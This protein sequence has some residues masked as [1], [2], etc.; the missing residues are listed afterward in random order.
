MVTLVRAWVAHAHVCV[1]R[2]CVALAALAS[3]CK[4]E[5]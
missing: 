3:V 1:T 4:N 2:A 5:M